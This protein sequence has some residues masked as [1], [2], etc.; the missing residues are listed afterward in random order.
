MNKFGDFIVE[1]VDEKQTR[2]SNCYDR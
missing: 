1:S 2:W